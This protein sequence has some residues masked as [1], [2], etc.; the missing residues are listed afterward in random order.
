MSVKD[1]VNN[2][3]KVTHILDHMIE[4]LAGGRMPTYEGE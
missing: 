3:T 4:H 2:K 1:S